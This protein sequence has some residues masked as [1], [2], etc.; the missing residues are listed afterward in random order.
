MGKRNENKRDMEHIQGKISFWVVHNKVLR[1]SFSA[2]CAIESRWVAD[3][4]ARVRDTSPGVA[5]RR[6]NSRTLMMGDGRAS[7]MD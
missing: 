3:R 4:S 1:T 6:G 2:L 7:I 5:L